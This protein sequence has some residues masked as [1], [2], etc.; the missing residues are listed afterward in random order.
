MKMAD[1][2]LYVYIQPIFGLYFVL[3]APRHAPLPKLEN[4]P[5]DGTF[6]SSQFVFRCDTLAVSDETVLENAV[7][8]KKGFY[9]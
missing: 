3:H 6:R 9:K 7:L 2:T 1:K 8:K 4:F 5:I